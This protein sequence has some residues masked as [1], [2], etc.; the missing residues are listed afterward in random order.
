MSHELRTPLNSLLILSKLLTENPDGNLTDKQREFAKT[1]HAAGSDLLALIN[2]ILDLSKI[3]SG[4]VSLEV[5]DVGFKDLADNME[6]TFRQV[7]EE[8]GLDF[9]IEVDPDLPP[10]MRTDSEAPAAGAAQPPVERLQVHGEGR[11]DAEDR[12]GGRL[13]AAGRQ[14]LDRRSRSPIPASA[15]RRTSSASSSRRSSRPTAPRA[16]NTAARASAS[17]SAARSRAC[18]A[19]RSS[20]RAR[21]RGHRPSRCSCRW[22]RRAGR[23]PRSRRAAPRTAHGA[24]ACGRPIGAD[25][26]CR[27]RRDDRHAITPGDHVVLI[28]ED[29]AMF[30]SVLLELA[31]EQGF[32][33]LIAHDGGA[34]P[35]AG[36]PLQAARDHAR[37]RPARHGRLGAARPAQARPAHAARADPR[38]LGR[39]PEEARPAGRRLRLPREAGRPRR[40][41]EALS[42]TKEFI[43]RPV[44]NLLSSRTTTTSA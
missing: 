24:G 40:L 43:D 10:A 21:R 18:S 9:H 31:R 27:P 5:G 6:R 19:A 13:A 1:I 33:G 37:H 39:R 17:P 34:A 35:G 26:A 23:Q 2:D 32:K 28:I 7:A 42:R 25:G 41:L 12:L 20:C 16:A 4:T 3:E 30:A 15:S 36:A 8:R 14:R 29:D 44:K 38:D 22:S 11:R